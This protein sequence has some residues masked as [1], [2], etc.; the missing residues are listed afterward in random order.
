MTE[1]PPVDICTEKVLEGVVCSKFVCM[2]VVCCFY[3][4]GGV[5]KRNNVPTHLVLVKP[6]WM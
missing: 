2:G 6:D 3:Y 1:T 5:V 4:C